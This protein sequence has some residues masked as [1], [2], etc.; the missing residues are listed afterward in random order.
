[1]TADDI[2]NEMKAPGKAI[3]KFSE[4][5]FIIPGLWNIVHYFGFVGA[6]IVSRYYLV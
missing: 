5:P 1:M 4:V 6:L 3:F 2:L